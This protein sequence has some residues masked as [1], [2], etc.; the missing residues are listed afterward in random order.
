MRRRS[1][2]LSWRQPEYRQP[3]AIGRGAAAPALLERTGAF[4]VSN[5]TNAKEHAIGLLQLASEVEQALMAQYLYAAVSLSDAPLRGESYRQKMLN[6]AVQEMCHLATVQNLLLAIGG[7]GAMY[8]ERDALRQQSPNNPLPFVL[9][10]VSRRSLAGYVAAEMPAQ[11]PAAL[12]AEVDLLI[13]ESS[14]ALEPDPRR[15]GAIYELLKALFSSPAQ[16]HEPPGLAKMAPELV[17]LHLRDEDF[18]PVTEIAAH[19]ADPGEWSAREEEGL[20]V[21][22]IRDRQEA[23]TAIDKIAAQGE[24]WTSQHDSHFAEFM[25]M[26]EALRHAEPLTPMTLVTSPT[27]GANGATAGNGS[28]GT[29]ITH[30]YARMWGEVFSLHYSLVVLTIYHVLNTSRATADGAAFRSKLVGLAMRGM[31]AFIMELSDLIAGLPAAIAGPTPLGPPYDLDPAILASGD[32]AALKAQHLALLDRL[33]ALYATI[34]LSPDF[35][36]TPNGATHLT[37]LRTFDQRRRTV[38]AT[39]PA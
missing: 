17:G 2:R 16:P 39:Q 12:Q 7:P 5:A 13:A 3:E 38:L 19:E 6:I 15:V 8:L 26:V 21:L 9:E 22:T 27:L 36:T 18:H 34:E 23:L 1:T 31:R 33:A 24:G 14:V 30:D 35:A 25:E 37:N 20:L 28:P 32:P 29:K 11:I 10:S 4:V